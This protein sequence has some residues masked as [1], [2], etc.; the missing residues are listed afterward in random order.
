MF[1]LTGQ[2]AFVTG[3]GRGL[4]EAI[5]RGL[6]EA[7]ARIVLA[8]ID[9]DA[10]HAVA[11]AMQSEGRE[12]IAMPLDVRDEAAFARCFDAAVQ[13]FGAIDVMVN[14]A[15]LT[16]STSLWDIGADEWD[17][18]MAINLRGS[19]FGCRIAGRHM[20]ERKSGR[21]VNL[22]SMAGQQA[23]TAT[24][25]H[26]AASK[27]ALLALTRSFAQEL[28]PSG[29]TVNAIAPAAI[30]SPVL[31]AMD[32]SRQRALQATIPLRRFGE[33]RE[34]AAAVVYLASE[35]G[36]FTTGATLDLNGGR[37]MR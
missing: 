21:I 24:G 26:Y 6:S 1:S 5:A 10:A 23:S 29:V 11:T 16:P 37:F 9:G 18:V 4:G 12:C 33:G 34:V 31:D 3:A 17:D 30:R 2:A 19:F 20:R 25:V 15:A 27:A 14:N 13:R 36:A 8:D 28:A 22:S 35:A 7:G 32:E